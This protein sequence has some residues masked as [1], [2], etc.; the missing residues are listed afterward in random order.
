MARSGRPFIH[1]LL[2]LREELIAQVGGIVVETSAREGS[3][4]SKGDVIARID[5]RDYEIA[6]SSSEDIPPAREEGGGGGW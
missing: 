3:R 4:V 6:L 2:C 1:L 5:P